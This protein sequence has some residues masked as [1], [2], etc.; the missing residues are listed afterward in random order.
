MKRK[1]SGGQGFKESGEK[2][3]LEIFGTF[4]PSILDPWIEA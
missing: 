4:D 3:Q 1:V 2:N